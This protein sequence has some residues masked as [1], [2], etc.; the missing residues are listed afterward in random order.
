MAQNTRSLPRHSLRGFWPFESKK[1]FAKRLNAGSVQWR[2]A[3]GICSYLNAFSQS[4]KRL[5]YE[6]NIDFLCAFGEV[7]SHGAN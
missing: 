6:P 5:I 3:W 4:L 2:G 7:G 1:A